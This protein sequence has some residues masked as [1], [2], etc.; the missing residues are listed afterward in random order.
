VTPPTFGVCLCEHGEFAHDIRRDGTRTRCSLASCE[1]AGYTEA[2][3]YTLELVE[4]PVQEMPS[5]CPPTPAIAAAEIYVWSRTGSAT[6][7]AAGVLAARRT[8]TNGQKL[9]FCA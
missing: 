9:I 7:A 4:R 1:C 2:Y 8:T 5:R 6:T 3:R